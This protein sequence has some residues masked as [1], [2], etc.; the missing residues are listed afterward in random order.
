LVKR[1]SVSVKVLGSTLALMRV[2]PEDF[3]KFNLVW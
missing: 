3:S 2:L 1:S